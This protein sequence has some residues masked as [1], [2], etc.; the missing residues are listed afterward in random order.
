MRIENGT[1]PNTERLICF[2]LA[3]LAFTVYWQ[4]R[5][6]DFINLD[7]NVYVYENPYI[8][9]GL[10][11]AGLKWAL[12]AD[13]VFQTPNADY[14][15]P[16]TM[17]SRM[18]DVTLFG[19][20]PAGHHIMNVLLHALN[21][22]LLF[23]CLRA[24]TERVWPSAW[25]AAMLMVHPMHVESVAWVTE[26]KDV[27][28]ALFWILTVMA[29]TR[30]ARAPS[31]RKYALVFLPYALGLMTKPMLVT[32]P[33]ALILLDLWPLER[34]D[35][36]NLRDRAGR[37]K[38][39]R[40]AAE[41]LPLLLLGFASA[42]VTFRAAQATGAIQSQGT[43]TLVQRLA[44]A[45][46][47]YGTFVRNLV[48]PK[49]LAVLYPWS[50]PN[51]G[52]AIVAAI[53]LAA[54]TALAI[55]SLRTRPCLA[56]GWFWF[57][58]VLFPVVGIVQVGPQSLADRFVYIPYIGLYIMLAWG[59]GDWLRGKISGGAL[60]AVALLPV[61]LAIP[62]AWRQ[63]SFW[64]NS[65]TL[66]GRALAVTERNQIAH[67]NLGLPLLQ[68]GR[69][70]EAIAHFHE[71]LA[72]R[73]DYPE[74]HQNLGAALLQKGEPAQAIPHLET[75]IRLKPRIVA[76]YA[77]LGAACEQTGNLGAAEKHY[78]TALSLAPAT[79][80][81]AM[82]LGTLLAR[83]GKLAEAE[84]H[85]RLA[86]SLNPEPHVALL[87]LGNLMVQRGRPAEAVDCYRKAATITQ[88]WVLAL[89]R[90]AWL[91]AACPDP[92]VR[93]PREALAIAQRLVAGARPE[94][95]VLFDTL[96]VAY[97][98]NGKFDEAV[99][100]EKRAIALARERGS[101]NSAEAFP[102][103]LELFT[104]GVPYTDTAP[105]LGGEDPVAP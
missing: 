103:R 69:T 34:L 95:P 30:Y 75:A 89:Q 28:S 84:E 45:A 14:W 36:A 25:V 8:R 98:A 33:C 17:L 62:A 87:N 60:G 96:A 91:L 102:R 5:H 67:N 101:S 35:L 79:A 39:L 86:L 65:E 83:M 52:I 80:D 74:A 48:C 104:Q 23:L 54:I 1:K 42:G 105:E 38:A 21:G 56:V 99:E 46:I 82:S 20:A 24:L 32:L 88:E 16:M 43:A 7:D 49:G 26:R 59:L 10:T 61:L 97:A 58:G 68:A 90:L 40:L 100:A 22:V 92:N 55:Q 41:K 71:A 77:N 12:Q 13:L 57:L 78:R 94:S 85:L 47:G 19:L 70:D 9:D 93:C 2:G 64:R 27:L 18:L 76:P 81:L 63:V 4:V 50:P 44:T 29:Y 51:L 37:S 6:F 66:F 15:Q 72:I 53:V 31:P 73:A 3:L 11:L